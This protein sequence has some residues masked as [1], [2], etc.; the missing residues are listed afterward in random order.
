[1]PLQLAIKESSERAVLVIDVSAKS[2]LVIAA[3]VWY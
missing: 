1:M 2:D 3:A